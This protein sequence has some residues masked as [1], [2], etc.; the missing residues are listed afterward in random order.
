MALDLLNSSSL[1]SNVLEII[2]LEC[3]RTRKYLKN[4]IF[5]SRKNLVDRKFQDSEHDSGQNSSE[6]FQKRRKKNLRIKFYIF[7]ILSNSFV[8]LKEQQFRNSGKFRRSRI[9]RYFR[10]SDIFGYLYAS[11]RDSSDNR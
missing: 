3:T 6:F 5:G 7:H 11:I 2:I 9:T 10:E 4:P 1:S 8:K